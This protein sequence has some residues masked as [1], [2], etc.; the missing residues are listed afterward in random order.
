MFLARCAIHARSTRDAN[1][2]NN[3]NS[4]REWPDGVLASQGINYYYYVYDDDDDDDDCFIIF[5]LQCSQPM[6]KS[7]CPDCGKVIGGEQHRFLGEYK[8]SDR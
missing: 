5:F 6:Q 7:Q 1:L 2:D 4:I 3:I 8:I